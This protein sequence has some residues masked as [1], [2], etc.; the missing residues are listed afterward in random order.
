MFQG[1]LGMVQAEIDVRALSYLV[2]AVIHRLHEKDPSW[3]REFLGEIRAQRN[4]AA[5]DGSGSQVL[6][7]AI[8]LVEHALKPES[9]T[10]ARNG[11]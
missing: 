5:G 7:R 8:R 2:T 9:P 10:A 1:S 3:W 11:Q 4:T 6:D